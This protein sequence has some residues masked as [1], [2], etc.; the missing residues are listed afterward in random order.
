MSD[1]PLGPKEFR[2]RHPRPNFSRTVERLTWGEPTGADVRACAAC[3]DTDAAVLCRIDRLCKEPHGALAAGFADRMDLGD[4]SRLDAAIDASM[5]DLVITEWPYQ[6]QQPI[7]GLTEV[8]KPRR[9]LG[10]DLRACRGARRLEMRLLIYVERLCGL[11]PEQL[12]AMWAP[13]VE[14]LMGAILPFCGDSDS[15]PKTD[16]ERPSQSSPASP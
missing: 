3:P 6:L 14:A 5:P 1:K 15:S 11:T 12:D 13:D 2:L 7:P 8:A 16:S 4:V 9:G 10:A